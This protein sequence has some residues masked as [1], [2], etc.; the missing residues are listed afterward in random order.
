MN[1]D[2]WNEAKLLNFEAVFGN[3]GGCDCGCGWMGMWVEAS[4]D[5]GPLEAPSF[6]FGCHVKGN[7]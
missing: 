3:A 7:K 5:L 4:Q 1:Y 2:R 6:A